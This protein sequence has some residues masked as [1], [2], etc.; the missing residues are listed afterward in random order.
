MCSVVVFNALLKGPAQMHRPVRG[1]PNKISAV[2]SLG[3]N[4][5]SW[6]SVCY[7]YRHKIDAAP[8]IRRCRRFRF[9]VSCSCFFDRLWRDLVPIYTCISGNS[10]ASASFVSCRVRVCFLQASESIKIKLANP[11]VYT[12]KTQ[13]YRLCIRTRKRNRD[14]NLKRRHL[15]CYLQHAVRR[16]L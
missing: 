1:R 6:P 2:W 13:R 9:A 15:Y 16:D 5:T 7:R 4:A 12:V 8:V 11:H 10:L 14:T 3:Q